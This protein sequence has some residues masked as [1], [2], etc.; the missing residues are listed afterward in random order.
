MKHF[1]TG[2][3]SIFLL[4]CAMYNI[5]MAGEDVSRTSAVSDLLAANNVEI[6]IKAMPQIHALWPEQPNAYVELVE[7][8]AGILAK[9]NSNAVARQ[10]LMQLFSNTMETA[11]MP[12]REDSALLLRLKC[13]ATLNYLNIV[14]LRN[15]ES[16]WI[17]IAKNIGEIRSQIIPDYVKRGM[18][19]PHGIMDASPQEAEKI[20]KN[21]EKNIAFDRFQQELYVTNR[22]LT[23][24]L[25]NNG[26]RLCSE[27]DEIRKEQFMQ[28]IKSLSRLSEEESKE[29]K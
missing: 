21:N 17:A 29:L 5:S 14:E 6:T 18:L 24:I 13:N 10:A 7:Q 3:T 20:K 16:T 27:Y 26:R 11:V 19:N 25:M 15:G 8:A 1:I 22:K 23:L 28:R 2:N 4:A 12:D 9:A